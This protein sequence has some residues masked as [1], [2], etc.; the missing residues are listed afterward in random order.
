MT[1]P[2][3]R[4]DDSPRCFHNVPPPCAP[5]LSKDAPGQVR[6]RRASRRARSGPQNVSGLGRSQQ[7]V[8]QTSPGSPRR[9]P[10]E[11]VWAG[12]PEPGR[13]HQHPGAG[14]GPPR[15][16]RG[17]HSPGPGRAFA[18][19]GDPTPAAQVSASLTP[20][21]T[22]KT[23]EGVKGNLPK[24]EQSPVAVWGRGR[25]SASARRGCGALEGGFRETEEQS[26]LKLGR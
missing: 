21:A 25:D 7:T 2:E 4:G 5:A 17:P 14:Q 15:G 1:P 13:S 19:L 22:G 3:P 18:A 6:G 10:Q 20:G 24:E 12:A 11:A 26:G 9:K 8:P 16:P 23:S